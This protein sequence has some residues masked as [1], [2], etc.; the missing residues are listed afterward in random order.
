MPFVIPIDRENKWIRSAT[1]NFLSLFPVVLKVELEAGSHRLGNGNMA[2][3]LNVIALIS[4][5][6]D[7]IYSILHCLQNGHR[8]VAL[9]NVYPLPRDSNISQQS[10]VKQEVEPDEDDLNS[11]MYQTVG[12]TVIPLYEQALGIPLYRQPIVG[13]A[14]ARG[15]TYEQPANGVDETESLVP[16]LKRIIV[17][18]PEANAVSTGAILSTYQR[19]RVES[20]ALRLGLVPLSFLWKYPLL[21][22]E[23]QTSLLVDMASV[24]LDA[25]II[26]IA[27]WGLNESFL[28]QNVASGEVMR[29]IE[30]AMAR[31]RTNEDGAALGEGGEFETLVL[32]GP[33]HL[34][35]GRIVV[36]EEDR[37]VIQGSADTAWVRINKARVEMKTFNEE[38][39]DISARIPDLLSGDFKKVTQTLDLHAESEEISPAEHQNTEKFWQTHSTRI[40]LRS[41]MEGQKW[42]I[43]GLMQPSS[44]I[45]EETEQIIAQI[46]ASLDKQ[47]MDVADVI[48]AVIL[49]RSMSHFANVNKVCNPFYATP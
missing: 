46:K 11:Y 13:R 48:S 47:D 9:G 32:D 45:E 20:I 7:S 6:K 14:V 43:V 40:L 42:M 18:H 2:H 44:T 34:F 17:A 21:P 12:H 41:T 35:K 39:H 16:L 8:V 1:D 25:R 10:H 26:K 19:T 28:W 27:S 4:G 22:P 38:V 37:R 5:G 23:S 33:D 36:E 31:F 49:L 15:S 30:R 3:S 29:K 24:G